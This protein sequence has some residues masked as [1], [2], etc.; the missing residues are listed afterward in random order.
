M[1]MM[2]HGSTLTSGNRSLSFWREEEL[3]VVTTYKNK[4]ESPQLYKGKDLTRAIE[5]F[6]KYA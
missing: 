2:L 5:V 3:W 6:R 4:Y 1:L